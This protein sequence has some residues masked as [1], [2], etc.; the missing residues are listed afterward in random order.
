MRA[1]YGCCLLATASLL[2]A[3]GNSN[4]N[5]PFSD[6]G[7]KPPAS[8]YDGPLF[9][10]SQDYP[11]H[12]PSAKEMPSFFK[13]DF[14]KDW[15]EY[16]MQAREYCLQGNADS[17]WRVQENKVRHWYHMPWQHAGNKGREAIHGLTKEAPI[18]SFQLA[19]TQTW[20]AGT[21]YAVGIYNSYGGYAIGQ[22]WKNHSHP[23][24]GFA[25][26]R[27]FPV[28]TVA[29]KAL[30][31][32][33]PTNL[34]AEQ[35]PYLVDPV[36]WQAYTAP[37]DKSAERKVRDVTLIQMDIMARDER[38]SGGWVFGT[39]Q[40]NGLMHRSDRWDNLVPVGL[41]WGNDPQDTKNI[42]VTD[43][44][45]DFPK[46]QP[47]T[48]TPIDAELTE[49]VINPRSS[50][51]PATHLGWN[52]RLNG[53]VDKP[54]SSCMSCHMTASFPAQTDS[55]LFTDKSERP[56]TGTP[57]WSAWWMRWF[58]NTGWKN[59]VLEKF[60]KAKYALDF[61]L[62]LDAALKN[63]YEVEDKDKFKPVRR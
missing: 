38:A 42:P 41:M 3:C 10:L 59:G 45:G 14:R 25:T 63:F 30:F 54:L 5:K 20:P 32:N 17:E 39:F 46:A 40:Y 2:V 22:V 51:L 48:A 21:A 6:Y 57:E 24:L 62:Q 26:K 29:C 43:S 7:Y 37:I 55:P 1:A 60:M 11:S 52:G 61:S 49:T 58:Q 27:G 8:E 34:V 33:M 47:I 28:G 4:P 53:P 12:M 16:M 50:E 13:I 36:R 18:E 56:P 15:R 9:E 35:I 44:N 19:P 23:N 31:L